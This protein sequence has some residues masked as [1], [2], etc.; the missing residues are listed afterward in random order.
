MTLPRAASTPSAATRLEISLIAAICAVLCILLGWLS[1]TALNPDGVS[2]L[3]IAAKMAAGDWTAAVQGYWSPLYPLLL[4]L[5]DTATGATGMAL[6]TQVHLLNVGIAI[7]TIGLLWRLA[8]RHGDPIVARALFAAFLLASAR[9][10]RLDAVTPDVLL[11]GVVVG[12]A[13]ELL[14]PQG[15]RW[16]ALGAWLG[17]IFL[18][19][20]SS[21]PW[22]LV[23]VALLAAAGGK[24]NRGTL[25]RA[26]AVAFAVMAL[27]VV[28][29]SRKAGRPT[30]GSAGTFNACWYLDRCD[31][32]T[33]DVHSGTHARY[34]GLRLADGELV[35]VADFTNT[36][37]TY[38]PWSDP[39]AWQAEVGS[40]M[41]APLNFSDRVF[42]WTRQ[43][44]AV[45]LLWTPQLL[46]LVL[47]PV[48]L[49]SWRRGQ[50]STGW[51]EQPMAIL[52]VLLG[53]AGIAQ[54]VAVHAEPRLIAPFV[55]LAAIGCLWW[56]RP[57]GT[58]G[59]ARP[60][61]PRAVLA[62]TWIGLASAL[63]RGLLY[64][65]ELQTRTAADIARFERLT[66][67]GEAAVPGGLQGRAVVVVGP[68][69]PVV[70]DAW[71]FGARIVAQIPPGSAERVRRWSP[72]Q[73]R[74]MLELLGQG[75]GDVVWMSATNGSI[76]MA[77]IVRSAP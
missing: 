55:L 66:R 56:W 35:A 2:Y 22:M 43:A 33:P 45:L 29:L 11:I 53:L 46:V 18:T 52:A 23:A 40:I 31:S 58:E 71:L 54:F 65:P 73:Q 47:L 72:A 68:A 51:R 44:G 14:R 17:L 26:V 5:L 8:Q 70:S 59:T 49:V 19:K 28:P 63:V 24:G 42:Y 60:L 13:G 36:Q 77:P 62:L 75:E 69:I 41:R 34:G 32:R 21:W 30:L 76:L 38:A 57:P 9:T 7:G 67:A 3:D 6:L 64:L 15:A 16:L 27:W 48:A 1:R 25:G 50:L 12:F 74:E 61:A 39:T 10:P 20:T 4:A 37:W